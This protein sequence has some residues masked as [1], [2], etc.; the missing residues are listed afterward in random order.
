[1]ISQSLSSRHKEDTK[2]IALAYFR[3]AIA[4]NSDGSPKAHELELQYLSSGQRIYHELNALT[5]EGQTLNALGQYY[6]NLAQSKPAIESFEK[7][8]DLAQKAGRND[9][10]AQALSGL[11]NAYQKEDD[12]TKAVEFHQEPPLRIMN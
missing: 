6:L 1:M 9:V 10:L 2:T 11:G 3:V 5:E 7:A 8:Y 12:F 4:L